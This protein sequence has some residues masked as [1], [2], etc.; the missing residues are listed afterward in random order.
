MFERIYASHSPQLRLLETLRDQ[1]YDGDGRKF[2]KD[3]DFRSNLRGCLQELKSDILQGRIVN[4]QLEARGE[5]LADFIA[6]AREA[7]Q[8]GQKDIAAVLAC[9]ALEDALKRAARHRGLEVHDKV[10][11]EVVNAL[12]GAGAIRSP[13]GKVLDGY[14][15]IRDK[16]F[17]AQ[18]DSVDVASINSIIA[19]T[20]TFLVQQFSPTIDADSPGNP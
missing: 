1:V 17:H 2:P 8:T 18:W 15:K 11:S 4:I 7:L 6:S 9:A 13:Q 16:T 10:M 14:V 3:L 19:F 12:K 5:V 20:E